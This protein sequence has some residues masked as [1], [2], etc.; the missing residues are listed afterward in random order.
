MIDFS[1][2]NKKLRIV[3]GII[4]ILIV[5]GMVIGLLVSAI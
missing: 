3:A 5:A 1:K 4:C 2:R